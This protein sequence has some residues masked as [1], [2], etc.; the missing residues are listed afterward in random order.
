VAQ[1]LL[2]HGKTYWLPGDEA[3]PLVMDGVLEYC[4]GDDRR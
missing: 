3:H 4:V 2:E 1:A